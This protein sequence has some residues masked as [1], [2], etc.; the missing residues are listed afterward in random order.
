MV[1]VEGGSSKVA[2]QLQPAKCIAFSGKNGG[3]VWLCSEFESE[4]RDIAA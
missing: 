4:A 1:L 2:I 3:Q